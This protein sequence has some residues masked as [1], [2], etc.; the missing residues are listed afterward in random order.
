MK[1]MEK[2]TPS[3][4]KNEAQDLIEDIYKFKRERCEGL[5][6]VDSIIEYSFKFDIPIQEIGNVLADHKEFLS[7]FEKQLKREFYIKMSEDEIE[8]FDENEW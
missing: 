2:A 4:Y 5:S 6:L 3:E 8:N 1:N 7:L